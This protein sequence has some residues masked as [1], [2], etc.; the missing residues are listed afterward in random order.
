MFNVLKRLFSTKVNKD[1]ETGISKSKVQ[2]KSRL[3]FVLVQD[4]A[5][6]NNEE[7]ASFRRELLNVIEK[8]FIV[9]ENDFD[10]DYKRDGNSTRLT[11]NSPVVVKR[12]GK[13][14]SVNSNASESQ[15][16]EEPEHKAQDGIKQEDNTS[17]EKLEIKLK[18]NG[19][20]RKNFSNNQNFKKKKK[21]SNQ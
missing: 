20:G 15:K 7:L 8:Y 16:N 9:K 3:Q 4:R 18:D 21:A 6:L 10:I 2:A 12:I 14:K 19:L 5:G 11:I 17:E 1:S 13:N